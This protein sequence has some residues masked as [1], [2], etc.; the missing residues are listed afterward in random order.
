MK[1]LNR[2][3]DAYV[4][5]SEKGSGDEKKLGCSSVDT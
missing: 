5:N 3:L 4:W 1:M 2:K